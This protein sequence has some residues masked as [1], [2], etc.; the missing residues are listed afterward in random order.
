[1]KELGQDAGTWIRV[2]FNYQKKEN[3]QPYVPP[4]KPVEPKH[5]EPKKPEEPK[6]DPKPVEPKH[7]D[8]PQEDPKKPEE[9][10]KEPDQKPKDPE[11]KPVVP[12]QEKALILE[13]TYGGVD[14]T[15]HVMELYK[16][17]TR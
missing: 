8:K 16:S 12:K 2:I 14:I 15:Q 9:K 7:E 4:A 17:G 13:A 3:D 10:P 5:E 11:V 1:M 6:E